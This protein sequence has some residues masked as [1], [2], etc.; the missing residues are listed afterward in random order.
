M[1]QSDKFIKID[2]EIQEE[3]SRNGLRLYHEILPYGSIYKGYM[4]FK[5]KSVPFMILLTDEMG[6]NIVQIV[7]YNLVEC[8]QIEERSEWLQFVN[9]W[10]DLMG[11]SYYLCLSQNNQLYL[12]TVSYVEQA[13]GIYKSF[14][15]G[16]ILVNQIFEQTN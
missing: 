15:L 16:G 14:L 2:Q 6:H 3:F 7:F 13:S 9:H 4:K 1:S 11:A 5:E 10:N 8:I 12:R